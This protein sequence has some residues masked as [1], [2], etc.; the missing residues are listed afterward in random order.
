[1]IVVKLYP[2]GVDTAV[3]S[4]TK[5]HLPVNRAPFVFLLASLL[6]APHSS[7]ARLYDPTTGLKK[8]CRN[9]A[10]QEPVAAAAAAATMATW[11][12]RLSAEGGASAVAGKGSDQIQ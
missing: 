5:T 9:T 1:M 10:R 8:V 3:P 6:P 11:V 12:N 2:I 4:K 7:R